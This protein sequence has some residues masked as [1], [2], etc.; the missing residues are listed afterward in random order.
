MAP[1]RCR[2]D[3]KADVA[4]PPPDFYLFTYA[5]GGSLK[6][7]GVNLTAGTYTLLDSATVGVG[8]GQINNI[9]AA[10]NSIY[11]VDNNDMLYQVNPVNLAIMDSA[12]FG[13]QD[14]AFVGVAGSKL[15]VQ[16][17]VSAVPQNA[18]Y[19]DKD[20]IGAGGTV[21][22]FRLAVTDYQGVWAN[23]VRRKHDLVD[24]DV[25]NIIESSSTRYRFGIND[26]TTIV[27]QNFGYTSVDGSAL[28]TNVDRIGS[29]ASPTYSVIDDDND[30]IVTLPDGQ[31][32]TGELDIWR[33]SVGTIDRTIVPQASGWYDNNSLPDIFGSDLFMIGGSGDLKQLP[34]Y[35]TADT[36]GS[37]WATLTGDFLV[38]NFC[39][40]AN[41]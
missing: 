12:S 37:G 30:T 38:S 29:G 16:S 23:Q 41:G 21:V 22:Y 31:L 8:G 33:Y 26:T 1:D 15:I 3:L 32:T 27:S 17:M 36:S 39:I 10:N 4:P 18:L 34:S 19:Y 40:S 13:S 35:A 7:F 5:S 25:L 9:L 28:A 14:G 6:K 24:T 11:V 2:I 20:N